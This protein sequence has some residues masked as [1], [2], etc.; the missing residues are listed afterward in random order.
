MHYSGSSSPRRHPVGAQS[1]TIRV[2]LLDKNGQVLGDPVVA[3]PVA[4]SDQDVLAPP[5]AYPATA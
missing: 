3:R 1:T 5:E 4:L 2:E